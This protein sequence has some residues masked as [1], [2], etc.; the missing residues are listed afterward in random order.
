MT[1]NNIRVI[2]EKHKLIPV[3]TFCL[4]ITF[5]KIALKII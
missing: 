1:Q 2:L 4:K 5:Y 3:V